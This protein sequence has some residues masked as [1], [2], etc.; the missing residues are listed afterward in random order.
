MPYRMVVVYHL[1][2]TSNHNCWSTLRS[3]KRVVYHLVPTSN[4]NRAR[5]RFVLLQLFI[6]LF[7]HQTTTAWSRARRWTLLFIILF[8]HQ[9]TTPW[10]RWL[11]LYLLFII[12]FLHQTTTRTWHCSAPQRLFII[13]FLHQTT[14]ANALRSFLFRCLSSC[15]YI[16]P[17]LSYYS[18]RR[19]YVVY[20]LV[21]TSNHNRQ[22]SSKRN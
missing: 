3:T 1:V 19:P 21:P 17:Q 18:Y 11:P 6:I 10:M 16:K 15:S 22:G 13:L 9:T 12:L 7:L 2:P 20:H 5:A 14:T 4:H 8:L